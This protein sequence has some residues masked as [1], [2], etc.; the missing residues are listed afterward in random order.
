[1]L[2]WRKL[3]TTPEPPYTED[4]RRRSD[5]F[6][7]FIEFLFAVVIGQSF[8]LLSSPT[9]VSSWVA[10]PLGNILTLGNA[11]L[12]YSLVVTSWI[13]YHDSTQKLPMRNVGRFVIDILL[14]F[15]YSLTFAKLNSFATISIILFA[16]FLLYF[17]WTLIRLYEY[18]QVRRE[19]YLIRRT[20]QAGVFAIAFFVVALLVTFYPDA[21]LQGVM[22]D[23]SFLL[24]IL[25]RKLYWRGPK[26]RDA[27]RQNSS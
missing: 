26:T 18:F 12:A 6:V 11:I 9:G 7:R 27:P 3:A 14:L 17:A 21:T 23:V 15:L 24:L 8:L 22:L 25:Y 19:Y 10:N 5:L 2:F 16:V 13:G 4:E 20:V 1:M